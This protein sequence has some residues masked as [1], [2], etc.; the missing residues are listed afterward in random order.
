MLFIVVVLL[1][2]SIERLSPTIHM[3]NHYVC[4]WARIIQQRNPQNYIWGA[5]SIQVGR[6]YH[7]LYYTLHHTY[8]IIHYYVYYNLCLYYD[9]T[10]VD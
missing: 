8:S 2:G 7:R 10:L 6:L 5:R 3:D 9:H 4:Y 1:C